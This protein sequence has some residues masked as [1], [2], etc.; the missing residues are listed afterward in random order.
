MKKIMLQTSGGGGAMAPR[1]PGIA[2]NE[3]QTTFGF[4]TQGLFKI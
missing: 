3:H 1:P 4:G 2:G